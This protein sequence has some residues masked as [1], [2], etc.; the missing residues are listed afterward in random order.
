MKIKL[1]V[2]TMFVVST[3]LAC[4]GQV[5]ADQCSQADSKDKP[6]DYATE[7]LDGQK[8]DIS[9]SSENNDLDLYVFAAPL[10]GKYVVEITG[11]ESGKE[12]TPYVYV[13]EKGSSDKLAKNVSGETYNSSFEVELE[14]GETYYIAAWKRHS[15]KST[16]YTF[17]IHYTTAKKG[18]FYIDGIWY[19]CSDGTIQKGWKQLAG[20]WYYFAPD[21]KM[22]TGWSQSPGGWYY[23]ARSGVMQTG[24]LEIDGSK[25]IFGDDGKMKTGWQKLDGSW[26]YFASSGEMKTGWIQPGGTWYFM[27]EDGKMHTGWLEDEGK[28]YYMIS[29]GTMVKGWLS[30]GDKKYYLGSDGAMVTGV[31]EID[32]ALYYFSDSGV[33]KDG[34][35]QSGSTWMYFSTEDGAAVTGWQ[36]IS[37]KKYYFND[38]C[39]ML[40]GL[41]EVDDELY[42]L[43]SSGAMQTDWQKI[44][45]EWYYFDLESGA[46]VKGWKQVGSKWYYFHVDG[47]MAAGEYCE[48]YQI[49]EDGTWTNPNK[50][51]WKQDSIGYWYG[52]ASGWYAKNETLIIDGEEY[53]FDTHGY[54]TN[55]NMN[56]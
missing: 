56:V 39:E 27:D 22:K 35:V 45:N 54:C 28:W 21:G 8:S 7:V 51:S 42:Y 40:I 3:V 9:L 25:Y 23:F 46:A 26:Y 19:C 12:D 43:A 20:D 18:W 2:G 14:M 5:L 31:T 47:T 10:P 55:P 11:Y 17:N 13:F 50:A 29:D 32:G 53:M 6:D 37:G 15:N 44:D 48:G 24:L 36:E 4:S 34:W 49:N 38:D 1:L 41:I 33:K 16:D 30:I 52:D